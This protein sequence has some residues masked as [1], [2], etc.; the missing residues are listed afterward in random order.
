LLD[1]FDLGQASLDQFA[2]ESQAE[3]SIGHS[4]KPYLINN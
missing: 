3:S 1:K 4:K 2:N